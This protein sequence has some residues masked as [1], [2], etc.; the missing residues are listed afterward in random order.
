[1]Q[2]Q[3][4]GGIANPFM[5]FVR[6]YFGE[7]SSGQ[8]GLSEWGPAGTTSINGGLIET[9]AINART[10]AADA[11]TTSELAANSVTAAK[12]V[13][14]TITA[15]K[16]TVSTL[17]AISANLGTITAGA[18]SGVTATFAGTLTLDGSGMTLASG[19]SGA[20]QVKWSGGSTIH[21]AGGSLFVNSGDVFMQVGGGGQVN[22]SGGVLRAALNFE[23]GSGIRD[24]TMDGFG[25][26]RFVCHDDDGDYYDDGTTCD[27]SAPVLL[28]MI[29]D[30]RAEI[31]ALRNELRELTRRQ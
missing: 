25:S 3:Y 21:D 7:A 26:G 4:A 23:T 11:I 16:L 13:A 2:T 9:D 30:L 1:M 20:N 24:L 5:F 15:D 18:I 22:V 6:T 10:I 28:Q 31:E 19:A 12:I 29:N 27:G 8:T 17:D 14:G